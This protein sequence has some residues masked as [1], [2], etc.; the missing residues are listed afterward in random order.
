[1]STAKADLVEW[2]REH[3]VTKNSDELMKFLL[4]YMIELSLFPIRFG[5]SKREHICTGNVAGTGQR[6]FT[7]IKAIVSLT[8]IG[9]DDD[10]I[11]KLRIDVLSD[12]PEVLQTAASEL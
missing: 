5:S 6:Q 7:G 10:D 11:S 12:N 1:M 8:V 3:T 2:N 9:E 4:D